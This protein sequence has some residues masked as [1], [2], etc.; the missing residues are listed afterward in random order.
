MRRLREEYEGRGSGELFG[1][2]KNFLTGA[3]EPVTVAEAAE[4]AGVSVEH[5]RVLIHRMRKRFR[6]IFREEIAQT[7]RDPAEVEEEIRYLRKV[8]ARSEFL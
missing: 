8:L 3:K 5:A 4:A 6:E 1:Y 7:V 2:L